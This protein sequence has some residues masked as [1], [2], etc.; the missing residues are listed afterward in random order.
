MHHCHV[1]MRI[2]KIAISDIKK[3]MTTLTAV[4]TECILRDKSIEALNNFCWERLTTELETHAPTLYT[5]LKGCIDVKM[6]KYYPSKWK[7]RRTYQK[8]DSKLKSD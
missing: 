6:R 5:I 7:K 4:K 8:G 2:L 3:E 1:R